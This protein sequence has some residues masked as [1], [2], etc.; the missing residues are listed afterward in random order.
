MENDA[1]AAA[2][3]EVWLG[4]G[5]DVDD[6]VLLTL[7]TGIGGGIIYQ[8][9]VMHGY[10]GMAGELGHVTI[11]A[12]SPHVCGC[13]NHGCLEAEASGTAVRKMAEAA[14]EQG[15]SP[16]LAELL[17]DHGEL[18]PKLVS[19]AA[20]AGDRAALD[21]FSHMG[22]SLGYGVG[23]LINTFNFPL[24]L[25]AGGVLAS[26]DL[27]SPAMF[28]SVQRCSLT[29]R[30]SD[31]RIEKAKLGDK[32]GIYGAAYLPILAALHD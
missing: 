22:R 31:T 27:F 5:H 12:G 6:L 18:T 9:R 20:R 17:A 2:L 21:I 16:G 4:A 7:G 24:Y 23:G 14:V 1:N 3:G 8:G 10:L 28:E 29:Y 25:L 13:S 30:N 11:D 15:R 19:D 26:W 32:A